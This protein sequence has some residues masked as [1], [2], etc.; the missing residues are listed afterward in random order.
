MARGHGYW[1][2]GP[3]GPSTGQPQNR[4]GEAGAGACHLHRVK[5]A[6]RARPAGQK[7]P[8]P[9][10]FTLTLYISESYQNRSSYFSQHG[11]GLAQV[12]H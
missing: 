8:L 9:V 3:L 12:R 10:I 4:E 1:F 2:W 5:N 11:Y 6:A 7:E